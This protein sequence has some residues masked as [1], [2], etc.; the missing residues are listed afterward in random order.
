MGVSFVVTVNSRK[1]KQRA[2]F[3][4]GGMTCISNSELSK[5]LKSQ[6]GVVVSPSK[7]Q[8]NDIVFVRSH[9]E[10]LANSHG[11]ITELHQLGLCGC[12]TTVVFQAVFDILIGVFT[13]LLSLLLDRQQSRIKFSYESNVRDLRIVVKF[14]Q[15]FVCW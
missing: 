13:L 8:Q 5:H 10:T 15:K 7:C 2:L 11:T 1:N 9:L 12:S 14:S 4:V 6:V 3:L